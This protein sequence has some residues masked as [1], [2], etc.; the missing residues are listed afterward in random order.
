M[1]KFSP[2][3]STATSHE[4]LISD[5]AIEWDGHGPIVFQGKFLRAGE[6]LAVYVDYTFGDGRLTMA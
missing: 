1:A 2:P 5:P 4:R 6:K 3:P